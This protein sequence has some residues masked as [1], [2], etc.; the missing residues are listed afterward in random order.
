MLPAGG[1]PARPSGREDSPSAAG[2]DADPIPDLGPAASR[3]VRA[4]DEALA[5]EGWTRRF[6]GS[7]PRLEEMIALYR[8]LGQEVRTEP[9]EEGDLEHE[10]AGCGLALSLFRIVYTRIPR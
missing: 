9:L 1:S 7:P 3:R 4:R 10:C 8:S 2:T 5:G 6:I